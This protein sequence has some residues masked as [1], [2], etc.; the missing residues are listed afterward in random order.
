MVER[1]SM[2]ELSK[3]PEPSR[4]RVHGTYWDSWAEHDKSGGMLLCGGITCTMH[5]WHD[6]AKPGK[7]LFTYGM[8]G[9]DPSWKTTGCTDAVM[10]DFGNLIFV[11]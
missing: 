11:S 7:W 3:K 2:I 5:R 9:H 6:S 8:F 4:S 10:D 1:M